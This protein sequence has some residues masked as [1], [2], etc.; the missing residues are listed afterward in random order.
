MF[1]KQT[2]IFKYG[3]VQS[4]EIRTNVLYRRFGVGK[5]R[6]A[7]LGASAVRKHK[8][9]M[10]PIKGFLDSADLMVAH[11]DNVLLSKYGNTPKNN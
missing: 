11:E 2:G 6:F 8:T 10:F 4:I 7:V 5:M 3:D 9:G 1:N